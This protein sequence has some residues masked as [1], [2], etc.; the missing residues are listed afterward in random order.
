MRQKLPMITEGER[1]KKG[2]AGNLQSNTEAEKEEASLSEV[3]GSCF[4]ISRAC[5]QLRRSKP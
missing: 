2:K 1:R 3:G 5:K 4:A